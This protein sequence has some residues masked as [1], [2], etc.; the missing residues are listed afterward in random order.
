M[1]FGRETRVAASNTVLG[2]N[3]FFYKSTAR[4]DL[5]VETAIQNFRL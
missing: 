2:I 3:I 1:S 5:K 4:E